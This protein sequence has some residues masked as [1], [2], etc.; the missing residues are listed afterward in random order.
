MRAHITRAG[1]GTWQ[2]RRINCGMTA[3]RLFRG[4][5]V[6]DARLRDD[7]RSV[8]LVL[9]LRAQP[10]D[11]DAYVLGL[12][13]VPAAPHAAQQLR[14]REHLAALVGELAQQR[15]LGRREVE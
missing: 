12:G 3:A 14:V 6:A 8:V 11:V 15:E 13:L 7:Q 9:E 5:A 4:E 1:P 10:P 2:R